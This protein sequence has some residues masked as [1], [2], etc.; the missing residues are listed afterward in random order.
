MKV[1]RALSLI[2]MV[3]AVLSCQAEVPPG[4]P[5]NGTGGGP[6]GPPGSG[7]NQIKVGDNFY[8]PNSLTISIGDSVQW[9]WIGNQQHSVT[10]TTT[11]PTIDSGIQ[12][13]G[14]TFKYVFVQ[15]GI[16][17]Y[18]CKIHGASVMSGTI[19]VQ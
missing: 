11:N 18:Y 13:N 16:Y 10:F 17:S 15:S 2:V 3:A 4:L 12:G 6:G 5:G 14:G 1:V 7:A 8:S 9:N 19:T